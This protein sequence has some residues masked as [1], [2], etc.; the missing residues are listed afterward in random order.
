M[1]VPASDDSQVRHR[2]R[3]LPVDAGI[4]V[5]LST[6]SVPKDEIIFVTHSLR[7]HIPARCCLR[8]CC[9]TPW[10]PNANNAL[11][12]WRTDAAVR[13]VVRRFQLGMHL[14]A[15]PS[16]ATTSPFRLLPYLPAPRRVEL[17]DPGQTLL[18]DV[19]SPPASSRTGP[20]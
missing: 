2:R 13:D 9:G 11:P 15:G 6:I 14:I 4:P 3:L 1:L 8:A 16:N 18:V 7:I 10:S 17:G 12:R 5:K 19:G 20:D